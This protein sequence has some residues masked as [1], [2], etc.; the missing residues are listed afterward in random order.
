MNWLVVIRKQMQKQ[1][2]LQQAQLAMA[3]KM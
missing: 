2:K 3:M 1:K